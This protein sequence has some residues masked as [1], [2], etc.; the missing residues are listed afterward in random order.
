MYFAE[1]GGKYRR[2]LLAED[3]RLDG[4]Y[5]RPLWRKQT[6]KFFIKLNLL[7]I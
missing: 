7:S 1:G 6:L 5:Q 4:S 3:C 2:P